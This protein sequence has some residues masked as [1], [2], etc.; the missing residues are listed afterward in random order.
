MLAILAVLLNAPGALAQGTSLPPPSPSPSPSQASS[1][2][3]AE[4]DT[5][6]PPKKKLRRRRKVRKT[7]EPHKVVVR[8]GGTTEAPP[9]M[10]PMVPQ[11]QESSE[12]SKSGQLLTATAA[13]LKKL[14]GKKLSAEQQA[15]VTQIRQFM[16]QSR[17]AL[18]AGDVAQGYNLAS[19]ANVL[20][21]ELNK[22]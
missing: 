15:T 9:Q 8:Q 11:H 7:G 22:H 6:K 21:E 14:D 3:S 10:A 2:G 18:D 17:T 12:R 5:P 1:S 16:E 4:N 13:N 20:S 19:K